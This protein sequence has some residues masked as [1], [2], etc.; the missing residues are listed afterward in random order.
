MTVQE[1]VEKLQ[2]LPQDLEVFSLEE[3]WAVDIIGPRVT[4]ID[5]GYIVDEPGRTIVIL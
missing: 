3:M 1:L 4:T 2:A 5:E